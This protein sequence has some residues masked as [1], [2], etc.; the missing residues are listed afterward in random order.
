MP[1]APRTADE[2]KASIEWI[3]PADREAIYRRDHY[4]CVYCGSAPA[5]PNKLTLDHVHPRKLGG[6]DNATNLVTCCLVCNSDK[7]N[8]TLRTYKMHLEDW[9]KPAEIIVARVLAAL[10]TALPAPQADPPEP[11]ADSD[12][13]K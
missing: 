6:A 1:R 9:G 7:R 2:I 13:E 5:P 10:A 11:L 4:C 3:D 8:M 12:G